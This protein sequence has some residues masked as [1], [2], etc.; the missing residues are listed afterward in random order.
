MT[1]DISERLRRAF[2]ADSVAEKNLAIRAAFDFIAAM[3]PAPQWQGIESAPRDGTR[4]ILAKFVGHPAHETALWWAVAGH[5]SD[6]WQNW[7]DG[8]EPCGLAGPT[9]WMPIPTPPAGGSD[10]E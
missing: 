3:Q 7:N 4:M 1:D 6:K 2:D 5:W 10:A 8:V 9:H